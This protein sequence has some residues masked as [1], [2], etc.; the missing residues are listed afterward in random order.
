MRITRSSKIKSRRAIT[1]V[2]V[3]PAV[4]C[5]VMDTSFS[6]L[7]AQEHNCVA[8]VLQL[9]GDFPQGSDNPCSQD[10][11]HVLHEHT[12]GLFEQLRFD[13]SDPVVIRAIRLRLAR[14]AAT[15]AAWDNAIMGEAK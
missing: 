15:C 8:E 13:E 7:V 4:P 10:W 14:I 3:L 5:P 9:W 2:P 11:Q 6:R 1:P 12:N